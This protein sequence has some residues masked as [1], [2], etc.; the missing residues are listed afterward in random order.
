[1]KSLSLLSFV[2]EP[3]DASMKNHWRVTHHPDHSLMIVEVIVND[4]HVDK[5]NEEEDLSRWAN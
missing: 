5:N 4:F 3:F 1:M 2:L